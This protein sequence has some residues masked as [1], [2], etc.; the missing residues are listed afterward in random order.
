MERIEFQ[1][2]C[3]V[4]IRTLLVKLKSFVVIVSIFNEAQ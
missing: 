2:P 3:R 4:N 1:I